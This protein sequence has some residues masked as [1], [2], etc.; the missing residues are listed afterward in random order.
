MMIAEQQHG[1]EQPEDPADH[2]VDEARL[3]EQRLRLVEA[4][5][6]RVRSAM[7]AATKIVPNA[8]M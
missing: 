3:L 5:D 4:L 1:L 7:T 2:L 6:R 8:S